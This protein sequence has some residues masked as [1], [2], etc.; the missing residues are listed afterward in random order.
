MRDIEE[1]LN[2][3]I[4]GN[5]FALQMDE[6]IDSNKDCLVITYVRYIDADDLMEEL[7]FSKG[8]ANRATAEELFNIIKEANLRWEDCVGICRDGAQ[9]KSLINVPQCALDTLDG[10]QSSPKEPKPE[11]IDVM[12]GIITTVS[13]IKKDIFSPHSTHEK[14]SDNTAVWFYSE[15]QWHSCG[16]NSGV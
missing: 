2:D 14:R 4:K 16:F 10:T 6:A 11:R 12:P 7:L 15:S 9:S 3:K 5:R 1:P 8:V 13:N